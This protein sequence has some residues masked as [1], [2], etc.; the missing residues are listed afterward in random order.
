MLTK[1]DEFTCHQAVQ[2]FD[3]PAV[4][5]RAW[6]EKLWMNIHD[7]K[8][9][10]VLATGFG[11]YPNR[12]VMDGF[13]CVNIKNTDQYNMRMSRE[14]RPKI[15]E[16]AVGPLSY[17]VIEPF[18]KI[19]VKLEENK[20]GI[21]FE[22]DFLGKFQPGEE[23]PQFGKNKGHVYMHTCRYAQLGK[24][25]GWIK[26]DGKKYDVD[27]KNFC[28]QRDHSWGIRMGVGASETGVQAPDIALF[29]AMMINWL[30]IQFDEWALNCY[31]IER[32]D[33]SIK[34]LTGEI[35]RKLGDTN[36]TIK[37]IKVDHN[38]VYFENSQ[39]M[40]S[41]TMKFY[42][43]DGTTKEIEMKEIITMYL[44][45][46]AYVGYKGFRHGTWMGPYWEDGEKWDIKNP[47]VANDVHGLDDTVCEVK[48]GKETGYGIIE[49]MLFAPFPK[50]NITQWGFK[51]A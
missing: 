23:N 35:V 44:R 10:I 36:D 13:A 34:L 24:A 31:L 22:L 14:L 19:H 33:G 30:V 12:N 28:A 15:D 48:C 11:V 21:S 39:R 18:K 4:T 1:Y 7:T 42:L 9:E 5:D 3:S 32:A 6:T 47:D 45:G 38:F 8:G 49:N 25:T 40:K 17:N 2:S 29:T 27:E 41:G 37:I 26:A 16:I 20:Y 43:S 46:G 50:Y 51:P